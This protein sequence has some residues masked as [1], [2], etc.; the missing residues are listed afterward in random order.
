MWLAFRYFTL[1]RSAL[2]CLFVLLTIQSCAGSWDFWPFNIN[3]EIVPSVNVIPERD[4][5]LIHYKYSDRSKIQAY[6]DSI[7][8]FLAPYKNP[9]GNNIYNC[10][11]N[12]PPPEGQV[13]DVNI[14]K[15][16]FC[17]EYTDYGYHRS[18]PCL[19]FTLSQ[20]SSSF[21]NFSLT[22]AFN[23]NHSFFVH[24]V[25]NWTPIVLNGSDI[26]P[27]TNSFS[28]IPEFL[29]AS[30]TRAERE[31]QVRLNPFNFTLA[32]VSCFCSSE[33]HLAHMRRRQRS[34]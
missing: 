1:G 5:T 3:K 16:G 2:F 9:N 33:I 25:L 32:M 28:A 4:H 18:S 12:N 31:N 21:S 27:A 20:A 24:K 13:C 14:K 23:Q 26:Q 34:R 7:N 30:I 22:F 19:L 29:N 15:L 10:D 6:V 11:F 17:N 8:T